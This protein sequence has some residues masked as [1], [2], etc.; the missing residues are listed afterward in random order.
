MSDV[1]NFGLQNAHFVIPATP[2]LRKTIFHFCK[3]F[4]RHPVST[5]FYKPKK[6][7]KKFF[8]KIYKMMSNEIGID[9]G[10]ANTL[11]YLGGKGIV[12]NEPSVVAIN[13]KTG[14]V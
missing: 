14:R 5:E 4:C 13:Q 8:S 9:L 6:M 11:V 10:T 12:V 3:H 2:S 1:M 7:K